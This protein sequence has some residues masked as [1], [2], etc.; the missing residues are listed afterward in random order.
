MNKPPP[1]KKKKAKRLE[2]EAAAVARG[3]ELGKAQAHKK[4]SLL[5]IAK[6]HIGKMIDRIEPFET[7][8]IIGTTIIVHGIIAS[9]P[10][11]ME[12]VKVLQHPEFL[13]LG[14][15]GVVAA[16]YLP[17][18]EGELKKIAEET[19]DWFVWL[20]SFAIAYI[21]VK[22]GGQIMGLLEKGLTSVVPMLLGAA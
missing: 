1:K 17:L 22:H 3:T 7:M 2:V 8:A 11:L 15:I 21:I 9:T 16:Q 5:E 10:A 13:L 19:P 14:G 12:K 20:E 4:K 6:E 18:P